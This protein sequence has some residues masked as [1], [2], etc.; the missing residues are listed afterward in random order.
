V[1]GK[2]DVGADMSRSVRAVERIKR[3]MEMVECADHERLGL[4]GILLHRLVLPVALLNL[5]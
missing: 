3:G 5:S 2:I 4:R 1:D